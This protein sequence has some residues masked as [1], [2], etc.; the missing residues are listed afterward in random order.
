M[1][2]YKN[3]KEFD[4]ENAYNSYTNSYRFAVCRAKI[5]EAPNSQLIFL[6]NNHRGQ[7]FSIKA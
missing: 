3:F 1:V 5:N 4:L 7:K 2:S 6:K